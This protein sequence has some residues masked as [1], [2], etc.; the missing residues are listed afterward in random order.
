MDEIIFLPNDKQREALCDMMYHALVEIRALGWAGKAEQASDLA[1]AFHNLPKE[2]YGWGRWDVDVFRQ[3]LQYYQSKFPR[4]KYG[5]FDFI[6][7]L[8]RI[9][10]GS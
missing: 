4:N 6:A 2:I 1:D 7:M 3:M 8:D 9:F 5:G 10:P